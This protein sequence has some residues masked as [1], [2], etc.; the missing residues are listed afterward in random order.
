MCVYLCVLKK[1]Y[2]INKWNQARKLN[3]KLEA[4]NK[5]FSN[6]VS[7]KLENF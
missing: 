2:N 4:P 6:L 1:N 7:H 3:Q 5:S